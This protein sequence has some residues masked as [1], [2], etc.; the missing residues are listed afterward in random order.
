MQLS[1]RVSS[2]SVVFKPGLLLG[3]VLSLGVGMLAHYLTVRQIENENEV[4]F[5]NMAH[6]SQFN[7]NARIASY[8]NVLRASASVF[9][10]APN[11]T[12]EQFHHY[13]EGLDIKTNYPAIE[14]INYMESVRDEDTDEF[15]ARM[16]RE[17]QAGNFGGPPFRITPPGHRPLHSVLVFIE[18]PQFAGALGRDVSAE[19]RILARILGS[20]DKGGISTSGLPV[21]VMKEQKRF[22]LAMRL[23]V[24]RPGL[25]LDTVER[26]RAAYR[27]SIGIAFNVGLMVRGVLEEFPLKT[28]RLSLYNVKEVLPG[29]PAQLIYDSAVASGKA[30]P[31]PDFD[32]STRFHV[33]L[34]V[35]FNGHQWTAY[36]STPKAGVDRESDKSFPLLAL[37]AGFTTTMLLYGFYYTLTSSRT[38]A[39]EL[40]KGMTQELRQNQAELI[41][42]HQELRRLAAHGEHI[43]EVERKRIAREIHDDLGQ[44]LLALRIEAELLFSRTREHHPRLNARAGATLSHIDAT[45]KSVRQIIND[46]RPNV[47]DLGLNAAVDW[48]ISEFRSRTSIECDLVEYNQDIRVNDDLAIALFRILQ[49]SLTNVQ[50]HARA[51]WVRVDLLVDQGWVRMSIRDNGIGFARGTRKP[52]S[53]GLI[54]MEERVNV[55]GGTFSLGGAPGGGTVVEVALPMLQ[56]NSHSAQHDLPLIEE[57]HLQ[58]ELA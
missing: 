56:E 20:R 17:Q 57:E 9:N 2:L 34:P 46:L 27:G 5:Q 41:R 21:K 40:A 29:Q 47:L 52:S 51:S 38:R 42:S 53:F 55:L 14:T 35:D 50:R 45:I 37:V 12:R 26:R 22:G 30:P 48:Q 7:I 16:R 3:I 28:V 39:V 19:P 11:I 24:F 32:D 4:R 15:E 33:S 58:D 1:R 10:A 13:V 18:P 6:N 54:G 8:T 43:K 36:L 25:P 44:N 31:P 23:P 49:E